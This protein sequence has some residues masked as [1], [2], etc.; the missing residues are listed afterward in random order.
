M[1]EE[2]KEFV[3]M[4]AFNFAKFA[5]CRNDPTGMLTQRSSN[6]ITLGFITATLNAINSLLSYGSWESND[7]SNDYQII[8]VRF[9]IYYF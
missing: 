1:T 9:A 3:L 8:E 4:K 7:F 6:L 2:G 5:V